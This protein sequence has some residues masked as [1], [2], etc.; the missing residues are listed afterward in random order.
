MRVPHKN[1]PLSVFTISVEQHTSPENT[2]LQQ[3][4]S[5]VLSQFFLGQII[6]F[7]RNGNCQVLDLSKTTV[8]SHS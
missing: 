2:S 3:S 6:I 7:R 5:G 8:R 1:T 4:L